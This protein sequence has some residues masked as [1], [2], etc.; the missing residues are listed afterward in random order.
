MVITSL[1][2]NGTLADNN[3]N[4]SSVPHTASGLGDVTYTGSS[5][6]NGTD[7]FTFYGKDSV[8]TGN[9]STISVVI[10]PVEDEATGTLAV[11]GTFAEGQTLTAVTS[12]ISDVDDDLSLIHI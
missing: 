7:S 11:S 6:Y 8:L 1:P 5:H 3:G 2:S 12:G 4:I 9:T 10:S